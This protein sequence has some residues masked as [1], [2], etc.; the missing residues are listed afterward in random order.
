[1]RVGRAVV[2]DR[3]QAGAEHGDEQLDASAAPQAKAASAVSRPGFWPSAG[4][5]SPT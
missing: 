1:M 4:G 5:D 2:A 3:L